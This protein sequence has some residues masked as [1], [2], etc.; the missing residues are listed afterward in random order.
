MN[1]AALSDVAAYYG[2]KLAAHGPAPAGV[3]WNSAASQVLRFTQTP[4]HRPNALL[5][6][7]RAELFNFT[8]RGIPGKSLADGE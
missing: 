2:R 1:D 6:H 8:P 7:R 3:D 5:P 4:V